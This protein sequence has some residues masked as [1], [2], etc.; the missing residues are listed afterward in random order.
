MTR[1]KSADKDVMTG[2][3]TT[4]SVKMECVV[5]IIQY[6]QA[7]CFALRTSFTTSITC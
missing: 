4:C 2:Q 3:G 5:L 1:K 6:V 7:Y